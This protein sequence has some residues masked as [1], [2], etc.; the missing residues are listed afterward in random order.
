LSIS[1]P[2]ISKPSS[3]EVYFISQSLHDNL[4]LTFFKNIKK[5]SK[6]NIAIYGYCIKNGGRARI[7][8]LLINYLHKISIFNIILFTVRNIEEEEY[9]I[10]NNIKR[11][12][13]K[14]HLLK[15]INKNK[16]FYLIYNIN[17]FISNYKLNILIYELDDIEEIIKLNNYANI[18]VI[19]YQHSSSFDWLYKNYTKFKLIYKAFSFSKYIIS[20]VPFD[21][22]YLFKKWGINAILMTNFITH[23]FNY[24]SP[25]DLS[26]KN[27][28]LIGRG[29]DTKKRF[30]IGIE[31]MEYI[32]NEISD[33]ELIII[34][35]LTGIEY[36][37][38]L[39][40]N[41]DLS[42]N[43]KFN[44]YSSSPDI[45]FK[46]VSLNIFPSI[47]EAFPM[48]LSE[49]KIYGIP[50]IL[51]GLDYIY[52]A[53][54]GTIIIYDD[55]PESLAAESINIIINKE[56][57]KKLGKEARNSMKQFNNELLLIKW[58]KL[59]LSVYNDELYYIK[60]WGENHLYSKNDEISILNNQLKLLKMRY[61]I[62]QNITQKE[63]ENF[64]YME[65]IQ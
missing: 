23:E 38:K 54:N 39:V 62:F 2:K 50:C 48:V 12:T 16:I 9:F 61:E 42:N 36:L 22:D 41:L 5:E 46:N 33:S 11:F 4:N 13:I 10:P 59:I 28:L 37:P 29:K 55:S 60:L 31:A 35:N 14:N 52:I 32:R 56:Y 24:V 6:I 30:H 21:S 1:G 47:S 43:I 57:R 51:I 34:S 27:I 58:I 53:K 20:I 17:L 45:Y 25:S 8:S 7:T 26:T 44:G 49:A 65:K 18:N 64:E 19:F 63:F 3:L 15:I 40:N